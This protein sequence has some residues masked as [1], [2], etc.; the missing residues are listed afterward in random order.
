[1]DGLISKP[2]EIL[3]NGNDYIS[4]NAVP[5]NIIGTDIINNGNMQGT[6]MGVGGGAGN[7]AVDVTYSTKPNSFEDG[8]YDLTTYEFNVGDKQGILNHDKALGSVMNNQNIM[9]VGGGAGDAQ[10]VTT[11]TTTTTKY[12]TGQNMGNVMGVGGVGDSA[13]DVT[14]STK[15]NEANINLGLGATTTTTTTQIETNQ[16]TG[17]VMGVGGAGDSAVDVTYSTKGNEANINLGLGTT[18]TTTTAHNY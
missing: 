3:N 12:E 1:M 4:T 8:K 7:S 10:T 9:G 17:N 11:T 18:T 15:G 6:V 2:K 5:N 13:V 16:N 14:Y